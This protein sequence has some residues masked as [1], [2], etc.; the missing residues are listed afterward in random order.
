MFLENFELESFLN[1]CVERAVKRRQQ[2]QMEDRLGVAE[3]LNFLRSI[4]SLNPVLVE[5]IES[6]IRRYAAREHVIA[7]KRGYGEASYFWTWLV[8]DN[9]P[10]PLQQL[11]AAIWKKTMCKKGYHCLDEVLSGIDAHKG[12]DNGHYFVCD[13]CGICYFIDYVEKENQ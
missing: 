8:G 1:G 6:I 7:G 10:N 12:Y 4:K 13:V 9:Y 3:A 2:K 11:F 5:L